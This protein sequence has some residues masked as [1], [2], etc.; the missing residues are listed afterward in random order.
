MRIVSKKR[1]RFLDQITMSEVRISA[2]VTAQQLA[3]Y[4]IDI[5]NW[6]GPYTIPKP[7]IIELLRA[8]SVR[9]VRYPVLI[10]QGNLARKL[11]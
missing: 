2:D 4:E 11:R 9:A 10:A 6:I 5:G 8:D 3:A 1:T 7:L